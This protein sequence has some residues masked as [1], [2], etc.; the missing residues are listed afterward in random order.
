MS[1]ATGDIRMIKLIANITIERLETKTTPTAPT[2]P[3]NSPKTMETPQSV[4]GSESPSSVK[5]SSSTTEEP[6]TPVRKPIDLRELQSRL[7]NAY[8]TP[9]PKIAVGHV[10]I[11]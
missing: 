7:Q 5:T 4:N 2:V 10:T 3:T 6:V 9:T 11:M 1:T 8:R